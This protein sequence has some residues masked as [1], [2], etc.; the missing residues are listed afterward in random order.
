[1]FESLVDGRIPQQPVVP[2]DKRQDGLAAGRQRTAE[3]YADALVGQ[4]APG[5]RAIGERIAGGVEAQGLD[6]A[7]PDP[8]RSVDL[9][10]GQRGAE[11]M[12]GLGQARDAAPGK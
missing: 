12:L 4:H 3:D 9:L 10:D 2:L 6:R 8:A 11:E 1:M 5:E 7:S